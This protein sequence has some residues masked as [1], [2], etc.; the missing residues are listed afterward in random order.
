MIFGQ[1]I[2]L[3]QKDI[4]QMIPAPG[5]AQAN[6]PGTLEYQREKEWAQIGIPIGIDHQSILNV[7]A[8]KIGLEPLFSN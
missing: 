1:I 8:N 5:Y 4:Q 3:Y 2:L 7:V 6:L